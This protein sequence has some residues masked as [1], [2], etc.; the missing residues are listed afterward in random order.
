MD[1]RVIWVKKNLIDPT[2]ALVY[3]LGV[4]IIHLAML[5]SYF[6]VAKPQP[7]KAQGMD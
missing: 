5:I 7:E 3:G 2:A 1:K 6:F 4:S